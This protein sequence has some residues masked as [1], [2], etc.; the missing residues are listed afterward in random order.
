MRTTSLGLL[1]VLACVQGCGPLAND[2]VDSGTGGGGSGGGDGSVSTPTGG[3]DSGGSGMSSNDSGSQGGGSDGGGGDDTGTSSPEGG[4]AGGEDG[5]GGS[6]DSGMQQAMCTPKTTWAANQGLSA[7]G[8]SATASPNTSPTPGDSTLTNAF[9]QN[10]ST[11]WSDGVAQAPSPAA[12]FTLDLG[13]AQTFN[14]VV[15]YYPG[16]GDAGT[17]DYPN[18]YSLSVSTDGTTFTQVATG[19][20]ASPTDICFSTQTAQYIKITQ[21]GT[22][23]SWLSIYE[24]QVFAP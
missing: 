13:A 8:W 14:Q 6:E 23:G 18:E 20:G 24:M 4:M 17:T 5:G 2:P 9:D 1:A 12:E 21:T 16:V 19:A 11:R 3:S 7:S 15:F 22:S 10:M